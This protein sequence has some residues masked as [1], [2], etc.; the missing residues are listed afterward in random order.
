MKNKYVKSLALYVAVVG[1]SLAFTARINE[2]SMSAELPYQWHHDQ[3][4]RALVFDM[5]NKLDVLS[6]EVR[7]FFGRKKQIPATIKDQM[8]VADLSSLKQGR[9]S[10]YVQVGDQ[11]LV[12]KIRV[13]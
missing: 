10:V 6:Y 11:E 4:H 9:Y 3:Q 5:Q 8:I 1:I 2:P 12:H 7:G 13:D